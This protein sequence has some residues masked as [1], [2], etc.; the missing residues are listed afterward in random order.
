MGAR[1]SVKLVIILLTFLVFLF[2]LSAYLVS[3]REKDLLIAFDREKSVLLSGSLTEALRETMIE[4]DLSVFKRI[5][6]RANSL[7]DVRITVFRSDGSWFYGDRQLTIPKDILNQT[8]ERSIEVDKSLLFF[9]PL[10]NEG[11]CHRCHSPLDRIRGFIV[12]SIST[13]GV[14]KEIKETQKRIFFFFIFIAITSISGLVIAAKRLILDPLDSLEKGA[15]R[16]R[17]GDLSIRVTLEGSDEFVTLATTFNEMAERIE[18]EQKRLEETV[19]TKT[20][21]L[22]EQKDFAEAIFNNVVSGI[23]VLD[24][25][26]VI[27]RI[28]QAG[29]D[30]LQIPYDSAGLRLT[31]IHPEC[32]DMLSIRPDISREIQITLKNGDLRPIGFANSPLLD[33]NGNE[34]GITVI[35]R[36]LTEVKKLQAEIR[37][38]HRFEAMGKI[39][40]GVA[41]EIRNP[42]FAIQSIAQILSREIESSRHQPLIQAMLKETRRMK[43]LVEE[44]L[45]YGRPSKLSLSEFD[46]KGLLDEVKLHILAKKPDITYTA[47]TEPINLKADRDKLIQVFLNILDNSIG[48]GCSRIDITTEKKDGMIRIAIMDDGE[49]IKKEYIERIF[50]PFFTTKKDGTGLGLA[51]CKKI[52][53]DHG[54]DINILGNTDKGTTVILSFP[55]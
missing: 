19:K 20:R 14:I 24:A 5:L 3:Q 22:E 26:G 54:G 17:D 46:L 35:F 34:R 8:E 32:K 27:I 40:S 47:V 4:E 15:R 33:K 38:K 39:I 41:H 18:G 49:G 37:N 9:K 44:L 1:L 31:E 13:E 30:I 50:E 23:V 12:T 2:L 11:R 28:N 6:D 45:V 10:I 55:H 16:I 7:G 29:A 52:I 21:E 48:A 36:D 42:I 53:E 43:N 51:I 25:D